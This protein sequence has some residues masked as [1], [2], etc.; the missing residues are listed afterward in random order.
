MYPV[1]IERILLEVVKQVYQEIFTGEESLAFI[2]FCPG[3]VI[4]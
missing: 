1:A 4:I 2:N 3:G